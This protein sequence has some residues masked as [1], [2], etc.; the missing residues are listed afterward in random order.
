M[1]FNLGDYVMQ[2]VTKDFFVIPEDG[3]PFYVKF[4]SPFAVDES[5]EVRSRRSKK[6]GEADKKPMEVADCINLSDG[7]EGRLIGNEMI[8]SELRAKFPD[9]KYVG[10]MFEIKQGEKRKS[11]EGNTYRAYKIVRLVPKGASNTAPAPTPEKK[12]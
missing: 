9:N 6:E 4:T 1:I 2:N 5:L 12:R 3:T 11:K 8:K 7:V 10:E